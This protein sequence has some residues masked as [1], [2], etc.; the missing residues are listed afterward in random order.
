MNRLLY[1]FF[2][3]GLASVSISAV[4]MDDMKPIHEEGQARST[5]AGASR[6]FGLS[7]RSSWRPY[8]GATRSRT[9][10]VLSLAETLVDCEIMSAADT[11]GT[12]IAMSIRSY[13]APDTRR[14]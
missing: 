5:S 7:C 11:A 13:S 8:G 3:T 12:S 2:A 9:F 10:D 1:I 4:A 6:A 14:R